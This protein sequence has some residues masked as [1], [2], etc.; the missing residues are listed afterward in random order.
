MEEILNQMTTYHRL[1]I[2]CV[3]GMALCLIIGI[4]IYRRN[5]IKEV[6]TCFWRN[7]KRRDIWMLAFFVTASL[8][9]GL[10][11]YGV[12]ES[13]DP[14]P[15]IEDITPP[16]LEIQYTDP[17]GTVLGFSEDGSELL[18]YCHTLE[19]ISVSAKI[20]EESL[21]LEKSF[22]KIIRTDRKGNVLEETLLN[23]QA[24]EIQAE[25]TLDGHYRV[26]FSLIDQSENKT[27]HE[28]TFALDR[29]PPMAPVIYYETESADVLKRWPLQNKFGYFAKEQVM[30]HVIIEDLVSEVSKVIYSYED[31]DSEE[32]VNATLTEIDG[33]IKIPLPFSFKGRLWV[34]SEDVFGH[35]SQ[36]YEDI[37][38]I[39]ESEET[40]EENSKAFIEVLSESAKTPG[41]Y[42]QDVDIR[43]TTQDT[44]SGIREI[45]YEAG[46]KL[47]ETRSFAEDT[48]ICTEE[49]VKEYT[50]LASEN[51]GNDIVTSLSF[52]DNARHETILTE[53]ELPTIH[54]DT[55]LP[56]IQVIYDNDDAM[57]ELYY[58]EPRR[59]T[60]Q[61]TEKNF[62]P[63]DVN[64]EIEGNQALIHDWYQ[65]G[66][67]WS[68]QVE[69]VQDGKY[70][71][72]FSCTDLAGNTG[73]YENVD[74]FIIDQTAPIIQIHYDN[75]DVKHEMYYKAPR[76]A[77]ITIR[78]KNFEPKDVEIFLTAEKEG[79]AIQVPEISGWTSKEDL[80]QATIVYDYD[81][82][83]TFDISCTDL[84]G[85]VI[86]DYPGDHFCIDLTSPKILITGVSHQSANQGE[87]SPVITM[88]DTYYIEETASF[89]L[90]GSRKGRVEIIPEKKLTKDGMILQLPNLSPVQGNDDLYRLSA[91]VSDLAGNKAEVEIRY[92]LNR[93][94]SVYT[95][96]SPT[97]YYNTKARQIQV[98]ETNVDTL[99]FQEIVCSWNGKLRTLEP[100]VDYTV[101]VKDSDF[102]WK[103]YGYHIGAENFEKEGH[104]VLTIYSKDRAKNL[105]D[106]QSK[107]KRIAFAIDRSAPD[108]L[109]T[110]IE[111]DG[112]YREPS[113][114][115]LIDVQDNLAL[116]EV[117]VVLDGES[118]TYHG[119]K[120]RALDGKIKVTAKGKNDWQSIQVTA[121]DMAGN[122][123]T[124]AKM[125]FLVTPNVFVQLWNHKPLLYGCAG[126]MA[127]GISA[128]VIACE[129]N[130][131]KLLK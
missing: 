44:Y 120:L 43:F 42:N 34:Q 77:R 115:I 75:T 36:I 4:I 12:E 33:E 45:I 93:F 118:I 98:T 108:I 20:K 9:F 74:E 67:V 66:E 89:E 35:V 117:E 73:S 100:G 81:G 11:A 16:L 103:Q 130:R 96:D 76:S 8:S 87:V 126:G 49:I 106:N 26:V 25:L 58:K 3:I 129:Y 114:E 119:D 82:I 125:H 18:P 37:G 2:A 90:Y 92:S 113:K 68:C 85:N 78:E 13:K 50:L 80:H 24:E 131:K 70:R 107:D 47:S 61:V 111:P 128:I 48:E 64:F 41:Y 116:K 63:E 121:K 6:L 53:E 51:E 97:D 60:I 14:E 1:A 5:S 91:G 31:V 17:E 23:L 112:M 39:A 105:S 71:F 57:N 122:R 94:G 54:I 101:E 102:G 65:E 28:T 7:R 29:E 123:H 69:F 38:V 110:G 127:L 22:A 27:T 109:I 72:G 40:H 15:E 55:T 30:V 104:Y 95:I 46:A 32:I 79:S 21:D 86:D 84:A 19:K 59:A 99:V 83:F 62:D 10:T 52:T 124:P 88:I 56:K